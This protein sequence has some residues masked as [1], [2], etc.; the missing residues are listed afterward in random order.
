[1]EISKSLTNTIVDLRLNMALTQSDVVTF[2]DDYYTLVD[3]NIPWER[4]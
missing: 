3:V 4:R 2:E 1:M